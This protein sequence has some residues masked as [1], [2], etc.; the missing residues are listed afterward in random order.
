MKLRN[1]P[2]LTD[3]EKRAAGKDI[4]PRWSDEGRARRISE[5]VYRFPM[6]DDPPDPEMPLDDVGLRKYFELAG[7]LLRA[8]KLN[9][10][11]RGLCEQAA[12]LVMGQHK[13]LSDGKQLPA[14]S[15]R[16]LK[17][18]LL[19]LR[20]TDDAQPTGPSVQARQNSRFARFGAPNRASKAARIQRPSAR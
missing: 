20:L 7:I 6:L 2:R 1:S 14:Y 15:T 18:I 12:V 5:N 4:D 10:V 3:S 13:L 9:T 11:N 17:S 8:G 19:A 16:E